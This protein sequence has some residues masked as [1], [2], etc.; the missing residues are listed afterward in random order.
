[1]LL[2]VGQGS[3]VAENFHSDL[4]CWMECRLDQWHVRKARFQ[5]TRIMIW[6]Y[7]RYIYIVG[8]VLL[9]WFC[10]FPFLFWVLVVFFCPTFEDI[11]QVI[12]FVVRIF[13]KI[14]N[15]IPQFRFVFCCCSCMKKYFVR[16]VPY[17]IDIAFV[18]TTWV[19]FSNMLSIW[20][21][22]WYNS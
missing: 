16:F 15:K 11:N 4:R 6:W 12:H 17:A 19:E 2:V 21:W 18:F 13:L 5:D 7:W 9:L 8:I 1:M 14:F 3:L 20:I 10:G 22:G